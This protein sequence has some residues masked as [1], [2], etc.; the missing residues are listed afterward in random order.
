MKVYVLEVDC[1]DSASIHGIYSSPELAMAA[2]PRGIWTE[3]VDGYWYNGLDWDDCGSINAYELASGLPATALPAGTVCGM[4]WS[5]HNITG[6]EASIR[7]VKDALHNAGTVPELKA[8]LAE[9]QRSSH[10]A[11]SNERKKALEAAAQACELHYAHW[12]QDSDDVR[13]G[14]AYACSRSIRRLMEQ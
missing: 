1:Y 11:E 8:I 4:S 9:T 7:A 2:W 12:M 10:T 3:R 14:A 6:D 5:G 13:A